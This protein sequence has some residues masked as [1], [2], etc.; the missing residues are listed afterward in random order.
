MNG[1]HSLNLRLT[2][3]LAIVAAALMLPLTQSSTANDYFK[4]CGSQHHGGAGW[5]LVRAHH[6]GCHTARGVARHYWNTGGDAHFRG[7]TCRSRQVGEELFKAR[8]HRHH[9]GRFQVV[10]F[11]YGS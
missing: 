10:R 6:V 9:N 5:Y 1:A 2:L 11:Q 4:G 7:W 8:C 3:A